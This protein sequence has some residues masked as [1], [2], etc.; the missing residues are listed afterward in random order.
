DRAGGLGE[1]CVEQVGSPEERGLEGTGQL[2][3]Q[4]LPGLELGELAHLGGGQGGT[5]E[6]PSL[7][8]EQRIGLGKVTQSL[9]DGDGVAVHECD[10][11][12]ALEEVVETLHA[13]FLGSNLGER[14]LHH[15]V[16]R[17]RTD[18]RAQ[19]LELRHREAAVLGEHDRVRAA[20]GLRQLGDRGFLVRHG[21]P[22]DEW[23][24]TPRPA[25]RSLSGFPATKKLR[26][27]RTELGS[28]RG[29]VPTSH[30]CAGPFEKDFVRAPAR[31]HA[32][33][34]GLRRV[35][36]STRSARA[37]TRRVASRAASTDAA[38]R[39]PPRPGAASAARVSGSAS[40]TVPSGG[41]SSSASTGVG[42]VTPEV[43]GAS[44]VAVSPTRANHAPLPASRTSSASSG[45]PASATAARVSGSTST[46]PGSAVSR[47]SAPIATP[48][49]A[50]PLVT[51][52][53]HS[54]T[55]H[56]GLPSMSPARRSSVQRKTREAGPGSTS[57]PMP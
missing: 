37:M 39:M 7:D 48:T 57:P 34:S 50:P 52:T 11:R 5:V 24:F 36:R 4:H 49:G 12:G 29:R 17:V 8:H 42:P 27:K 10:R 22:C 19:L 51:G 56:T 32:E 54:F 43:P 31:G 25:T 40:A 13:G 26:R 14:V 18:A 41:A 28:A 53:A 21:S 23:M 6:V 33:T 30:T 16:A 1:R 15:G 20:E 9:C 2:R 3:Q 35:Q 45:T 38:A 55:I 44:G 46:S 47:A